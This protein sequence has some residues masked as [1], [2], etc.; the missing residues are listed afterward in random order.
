MLTRAAVLVC[1]LATGNVCAADSGVDTNT[2]SAATNLVISECQNV[3]SQ[4]DLKLVG[5]MSNKAWTEKEKAEFLA[6][7]HNHF[8]RL[9]LMGA[10]L[11]LKNYADT[12]VVK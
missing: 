7:T 2:V 5:A 4:T 11:E 12:I 9:C 3:A 8:L 1:A 10:I 6:T